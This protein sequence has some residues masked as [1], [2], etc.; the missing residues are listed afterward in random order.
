MVRDNPFFIQFNAI[1][2]DVQEFKKRID[3][4]LRT[5]RYQAMSSNLTR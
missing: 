2:H 5:R 1:V 4:S 3:S